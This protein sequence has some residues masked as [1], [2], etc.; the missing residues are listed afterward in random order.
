MTTI[1]NA[2]QSE[3]ETAR[4]KSQALSATG[5]KPDMYRTNEHDYL[6]G[7]IQGL[8]AALDLLAQETAVI[9]VEAELVY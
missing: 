8:Q 9:E 2:I 3:I 7:Y 6:Y 5:N 4:A 1:A